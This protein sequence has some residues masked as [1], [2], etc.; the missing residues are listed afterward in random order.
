VPTGAHTA[1][2]RTVSLRAMPKPA[3]PAVPAHALLLPLLLCAAGAAVGQSPQA[4]VLERIN[5]ERWANGQLPP[6]KGQANL[7]AA[8]DGHS[9]AMS[10]RNF[11]MH[12]DP[13]TQSSPPA[14]M[15]AAG[16]T[17]YTAWAENIAA[18]QGSA[19]AVVAD[20]MASDFHRA[21]ILS[22]SVR[23]VGTGHALDGADQGNVRLDQTGDC[24]PESFANGPFR[25]YWT[26]KFGRRDAVLPVVVARE[27][28][29][30]AGCSVD[31]YLYG[32]GWASEYRLSN[33]GA[34]WGPWQPF[35]ANVIWQLAGAAGGTA[36][37]R[38]ELRNGAGQVRAAQ[39]EVGLAVA[40]AGAT[41]PIFG[42]GFQ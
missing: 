22:P 2:A 19:A 13:D 42:N 21:A 38:A 17:G 11:M 39:D 24:T 34:T 5:M 35:V 12:C 30:V 26:Q 29:Q 31:V 23:E 37:V 40:C 32:T 14:R 3:T 16:Y 41:D 8:A 18:G 15:T 28:R 4:E 9:L 27:A 20:W 36:T 25:H 33:D 7:D 6:L 1:A 10:Q